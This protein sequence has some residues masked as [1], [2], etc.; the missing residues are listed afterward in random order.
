MNK[1][2]RISIVHNFGMIDNDTNIGTNDTE[3]IA[4][5]SNNERK[6]F[7]R[8]HERMR[9][10][11]EIH[12]DWEDERQKLIRMQCVLNCQRIYQSK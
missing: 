3:R 5:E 4:A 1:L 8:R 6:E 12:Q 10:T 7:P 11:K 2:D 9:T